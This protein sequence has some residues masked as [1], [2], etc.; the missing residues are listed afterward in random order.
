MGWSLIDHAC[1]GLSR[2]LLPRRIHD[3]KSRYCFYAH[4][5]EI[6]KYFLFTENQD[7]V[8][9]RLIPMQ[10]RCAL[11]LVVYSCTAVGWKMMKTSRIIGFRQTQLFLFLLVVWP[12][13]LIF[14]WELNL[15]FEF[16][17]LWTHRIW[18]LILIKYPT[19]TGTAVLQLY[20]CSILSREFPWYYGVSIHVQIDL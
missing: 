2:G 16:S 6:T 15:I 13:N 10:G 14:D 4:M 8:W 17:G 5:H 11:L 18:Y 7:N 19:G 12:S 20:S 1:I 9:I 3:L